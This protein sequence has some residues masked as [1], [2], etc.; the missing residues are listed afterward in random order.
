MATQKLFCGIHK[1]LLA[2]MILVPAVPLTLAAIVGFCS[3]SKT[4]EEFA[5]SGIRQAAIDQTQIITGFLDER[6]ID[7]ESFLILTPPEMLVGQAGQDQAKQMIQATGSVFKDMGI[8]NPHGVQSIYVGPF[9]LLGKNYRETA[10]YRESIKKGYYISDVFLGYRNTPHFV[11]AVARR[12][13]GEVWVLRATINSTVFGELVETVNIGDS[14]EA[15]I[16]SQDNFFQTEQRSGGKLLEKDTGSYPHQ[17]KS[18]ITFMGEDNGVEYLYAS[19][20]MNDGKWRLIVRQKRDDA[21]HSTIT[22]GYMVLLI[23]LCGGALIVVL[24]FVMSRRIVETLHQQ[25][26]AVGKLENQLLQ[27][28]RLAELGEMS[29]GFAHEINNP[30]QVMKTDLALLDL[31]V[32]DLT[33][34]GGDS[35][36]CAEIMEISKQFALQIGRCAAITREILRFGRQDAPQLQPIN[37]VTYLPKV[38]GMVKNKAAVHGIRM[39]CEVEET[40]PVI[41]ADPGQLQQVMI[42]LLNNAIHAVMDRHGANGGE[43]SV[44]ACGDTLGNAIIA[45]A[46]NG[47]GIPEENLNKI[48]IPFYTTKAPGQGTGMGLPVCHS[49]VESLGGSLTV[50]SHKDE[51][52]TFTIM[53]PKME[54]QS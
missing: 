50:E 15:Y 51:G 3:F 48:F 6:R 19:A 2:S 11:V 46:D 7:L 28:A 12:I 24:A 18:I 32:N 44:T 47:C 29:A 39:E 41:E 14:G 8:I 53:V 31:T 16:V 10:W 30:L 22:A 34:K 21:F 13:Q 25:A 27:A 17:T 45:I 52:T 33:E 26:E 1:L 4:T 43:I 20:L 38:G 42:N 35:A 49:I 37:L 5:V 40:I 36:L 9:D 54:A 23:L